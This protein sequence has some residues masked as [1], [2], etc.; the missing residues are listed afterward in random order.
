MNTRISEIAFGTVLILSVIV[1]SF[2]NPNISI[3]QNVG[4]I[5]IAKQWLRATPP[6]ASVAGGFLTITNNSSQQETLIAVEFEGAKKSEIHEMKMADGIMIM[7]PLKDGIEIPAG[8]SVVLKPGAKHLMLMGLK[9]QLKDG[10]TQKIRL[11][12]AVSGELLVDFPVL[13]LTKGRQ[14]MSQGE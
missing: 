2:Y 3:A 7:R 13:S 5:S 1:T 11:I 4:D 14:L 6:A 9:D 10:Q 8:K 12:F